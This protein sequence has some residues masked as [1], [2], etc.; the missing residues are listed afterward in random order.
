MKPSGARTGGAALLVAVV[1]AWPAGK[2][3]AT[4]AELR[5]PGSG[6]RLRVGYAAGGEPAISGGFDPN[7]RQSLA[8]GEGWMVAAA[9]TVTSA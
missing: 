3:L 9:A 6:L 8:A 4:D 5:H 7:D 2:V 1:A